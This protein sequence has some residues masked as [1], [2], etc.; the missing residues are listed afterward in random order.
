MKRPS[1]KPL[2]LDTSSLLAIGHSRWLSGILSKAHRR[3]DRPVLTPAVCLAYA[4]RQRPHLIKHI[5]L[6]PIVSVVSFDYPHALSYEEWLTSRKWKEL[7]LDVAHAVATAL[8]GPEHPEGVVIVT[9]EPD[10]YERWPQI[11]TKPV[12][13][14]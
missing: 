13:K 12:G 14:T 9:G 2:L 6:L 4:G 7:G 11:T 10:L 8:P 5:G 3:L 1:P